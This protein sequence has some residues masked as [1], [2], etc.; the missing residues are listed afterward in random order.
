ML[1]ACVFNLLS[2]ILVT[3]YLYIRV[4]RENDSMLQH[5]AQQG[6]NQGD[7]ETGSGSGAGD[8]Q[9]SRF[10]PVLVLQPDSGV[11]PDRR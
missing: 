4:T 10:T 1:V 2:V 11:S 5:Q 6:R 3:R 8:Q 7:V 9:L